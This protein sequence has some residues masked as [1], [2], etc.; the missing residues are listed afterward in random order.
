MS[1]EQARGEELDARTDLFSFGLVLYQMATG[2]PA[3][4]GQTTA[5]VF[6]EILNRVPPPVVRFNTAVP[7]EL[8]RI[9]NKA[10]EKDRNLRYSSAAEMRSDLKRLK[11]ETESGRVVSASHA[12]TVAHSTAAANWSWSKAALWLGAAVTIVAYRLSPG[13]H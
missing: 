13:C 6:D 2:R 4:G 12:A 10:L 1:P 7:P 3:F 11:R 9:I 5:I 8:E